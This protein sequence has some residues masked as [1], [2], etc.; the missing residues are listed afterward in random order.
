MHGSPELTQTV[1]HL[2]CV[3]VCSCVYVCDVRAD[4]SIWI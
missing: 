1:L 4:E 3:H 2:S